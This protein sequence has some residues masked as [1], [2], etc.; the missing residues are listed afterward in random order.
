MK[1]QIILT[2]ALSLTILFFTAAFLETKAQG[3]VKFK[4]PQKS[5]EIVAQ[6]TKEKPYVYVDQMPEFEGGELALQKFLASNLK[7]P[8]SARNSGI[9]GL[10]FISFTITKEGRLIDYELQ[11]GLSEDIDAEAM[12]VIKL[13]DGKWAAGKQNGKA[14]PV[15]FTIPIRFRAE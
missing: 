10:V 13:T 11:K 7:Y 4:E 2:T 5:A 1:K 6:V 9:A 8:E 14:V 15:R 3:D 12:R